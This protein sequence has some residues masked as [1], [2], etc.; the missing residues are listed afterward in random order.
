M[1]FGAGFPPFTAGPLRYADARGIKNVVS[2]L[3]DLA[4]SVDKRF[5]P[6]NLLKLMAKEGE[7]FYG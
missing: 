1:I 3:K 4:K 6:S 5:T 2:T 7:V